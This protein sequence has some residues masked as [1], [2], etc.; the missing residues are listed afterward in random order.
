MLFL[1]LDDFFVSGSSKPFEMLGGLTSQFFPGQNISEEWNELMKQ[2]NDNVTPDSGVEDGT[3]ADEYKS[4]T[5][6]NVQ[7]LRCLA[8]AATKKNS[9]VS[10]MKNS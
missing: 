3:P 1:V 7:P 10:F 9:Q 5:C 4:G 8:A 2:A 6:K